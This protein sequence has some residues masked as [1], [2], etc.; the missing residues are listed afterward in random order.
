MRNVLAHHGLRRSI[1]DGLINR[2]RG[3]LVAA[4][5]NNGQLHQRVSLVISKHNYNFV[6]ANN[7]CKTTLL[8]KVSFT[9][10]L[11]EAR[12]PDFR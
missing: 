5:N 1:N 8:P 6:P 10:T 4:G 2:A 7:V 11:D 12:V 3:R 9:N